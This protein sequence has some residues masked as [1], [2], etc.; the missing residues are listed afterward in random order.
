MSDMV[1]QIL[2]AIEKVVDERFNSF[3]TAVP[4]VVTA[5][6]NDG[7]VDVMPS[8]RKMVTSGVIDRFDAP[9]RGVPLMQIGF[10]G[11]AFD[12]EVSK[13]DTVILLFM[14]RDASQWKKR[15]WE[16]QCDPKSPFANDA[17]SCVAIPFVRPDSGAKAVVKIDKDG[18][19]TID[20]DKVKI[21]GN[22]FVEGNIVSH[23]D[24]FAG[25]AP[26][27][28]GV[29]LL[30][31]THNSAVGPTLIP[32]AVTVLPTEETDVTQ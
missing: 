15:K 7:R 8:V 13:G 10:S 2:G 27:G 30:Q 3:E 26:A 17:N 21:S 12:L 5:V 25:P 31:H 4:G 18:V 28:P 9:V 6:R 1:G 11:M 16:K 23:T 32:N 22:L 20:S 24:V 19:V 14:S 29:S